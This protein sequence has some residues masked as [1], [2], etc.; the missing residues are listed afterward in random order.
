MN[1]ICLFLPSEWRSDSIV[2]RRATGHQASECKEDKGDQLLAGSGDR[3]KQV[4]RDRM[5]D[6]DT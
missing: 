1:W 3:P 2:L 4:T 6:K 5:F